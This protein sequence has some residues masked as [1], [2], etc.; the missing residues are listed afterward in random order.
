MLKLLLGCPEIHESWRKVGGVGS[1]LRTNQYAS[2]AVCSSAEVIASS[3]GFAAGN[4][5]LDWQQ[6][7]RCG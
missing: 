6:C 3:Y 7:E 5:M 1:S 4:V 2:A